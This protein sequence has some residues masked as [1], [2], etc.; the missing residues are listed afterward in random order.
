MEAWLEAAGREID[1]EPGDRAA[2]EV[3]AL[4]MR[5]LIEQAATDVLRRF[6]RA[7]GPQPLA[8][9]AECSRRYHEADLYLRQCHGERDLESLGRALKQRDAPSGTG[10]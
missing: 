10:R 7:Y 6:A 3:R 4:T 5:H 9:D 2:A 8:M 1:R